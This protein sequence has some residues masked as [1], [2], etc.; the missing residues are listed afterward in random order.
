LAHGG[1]ARLVAPASRE[2]LRSSFG[3]VP[4]IPTRITIAPLGEWAAS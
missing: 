3:G 2:R 4:E 1:I